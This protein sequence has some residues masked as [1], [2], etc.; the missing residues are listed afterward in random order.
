LP[1]VEFEEKLIAASTL[2]PAGGGV[3]NST[4]RSVL[5]AAVVADSLPQAVELE[6]R[7]R[8][9]PVVAGVDSAATFLTEDQSGKL[10]LI[11]GIK[12]DLASLSF[13]PVDQGNVVIPDLSRTLYS[14]NGYV[15]LALEEAE[16][17]APEVAG[18]LRSLHNA[19]EKLRKSLLRGT[20]AD[21]AA[22]AARITAFQRAL[23]DDLHAT[24]ESLRGQDDRGKLRVE[25]LPPVMR[26]RFVGVTGKYLLQVYPVKN[27]WERENQEEFISELRAALNPAGDSTPVITGTPVQLFEYTSLLKRSYEEA[28]L[29][30]LAAI[31]LLVFLHFRS[32]GAVILSFLPVGIGSIWLAGIMGWF[33]IPLNPANIM[34]LPLVIGIGVTNGIHILNRYAEEQSPSILAKSTGKAVLVSGLTTIAGFGSLALAKHRGIESL[35]YVMATG[36][37]MCM[38]GGL[39]FLPALLKLLKR[40]NRPKTN[41]PGDD[42]A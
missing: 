19:V 24:F 15:G 40:T 10:R 42:N 25:D 33:N 38:L 13:A 37:A 35:G 41:Q 5:F 39:T 26:D 11:G 21:Q 20:P 22:G 17:K 29:Y 6:A 4:G 30:A 18:Q 36:V 32:L 14:F 9:L 28:A 12:Q 2:P 8:R 16:R 34:T 23:F 27:V 7:I 1:A 31:A 3:T